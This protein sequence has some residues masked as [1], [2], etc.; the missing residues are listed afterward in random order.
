MMKENEMNFNS[1]ENLN[2]YGTITER[3]RRSHIVECVFSHVHCVCVCVFIL[4]VGCIWVRVEAD[5]LSPCKVRTVWALELFLISSCTCLDLY[6]NS[7]ALIV[8]NMSPSC[9]PKFVKVKGHT[10]RQRNP[11]SAVIYIQY[12]GFYSESVT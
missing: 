9:G 4:G 5:G 1:L 7:D 12:K 10:H 3:W 11:M 8:I 6:M 2:V